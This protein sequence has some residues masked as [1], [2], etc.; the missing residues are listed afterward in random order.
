MKQINAV[1]LY[2]LITDWLDIRQIE[3]THDIHNWEVV[4]T[5]LESSDPEDGGGHYDVILKHKPTGKFYET[6][7]SD[8]DIDN[9]DFDEDNMCMGNRCDLSCRLTEIK[10][11]EVKTTIYVKA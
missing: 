5:S 7:Y 6:S 11:M 9:T 8:W 2:I 4:K 1:S 3:Q 10:P